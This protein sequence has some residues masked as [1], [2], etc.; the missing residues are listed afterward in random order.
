[1][2]NVQRLIRVALGLCLAF[3]AVV[4]VNGQQPAATPTTQQPANSQA[5]AFNQ[6][7]DEFD[8][9]ALDESRWERF[10]FEG[11]GGKLELKDGQLRLRSMNHTRSGVRS[12][13]EFTSDRFSV[14]A[15]VARVGQQLLEPADKSSP[16]GFATLTILFDSGGRNRIE[17]ILT[18]EG[19]FEA[20]AVV[21][22]QGERLDNRK[23]GTKLKNPV[24]AVI[25]R[26]DE[27]LFI[28]NGPDSPPQDAQV[29]LTKVI[30]NMPRAFR[31]MLYGFGSSEND[32]DAVRVVTPKQP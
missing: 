21:D 11:G 29:G 10:S 20:W 13:Q 17:W 26:G 22:G 9:N 8:G 18:S 6:W 16:L 32:W 28:L 24:L 7:G 1:M 14:E 27:F 12:K 3:V 23:L 15:R 30:K 5:A 4:K 25:R 2:L 19:T 31:V